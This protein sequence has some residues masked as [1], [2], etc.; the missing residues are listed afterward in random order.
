MTFA[1]IGDVHDRFDVLGQVVD[2]VMTTTPDLA[3][4]L[5]PGDVFDKGSTIA[6]RNTLKE[7]I[8]RMANHAPVYGVYGNHDAPGDLA[9]FEDIGAE[10]P[11]VFADSPGV[12]VVPLPER[13]VRS[14]EPEPKAAILFFPYPT[15]A[16]LLRRGVNLPDIPNAARQALEAM[17]VGYGHRMA[18]YQAK[19][20]STL[21]IGHCDAVG[22]VRAIGQPTVGQDSIA[23]DDGLLNYLPKNCPVLLNHIHRAQDV[24]RA[25]YAG[26]ICRLTWGEVEAKSYTLWHRQENG[27]RWKRHPVNVPP[28]YHVECMLTRSGVVSWEATQGPDGPPEDMPGSW[29]G[30]AVRLRAKYR[31][32]EGVVL[33]EAEKEARALFAEAEDFEFEPVCVPDRAVRAPEVAAARTLAE[34]IQ[35]WATVTGTVLPETALMK[36]ALLETTDPDALVTQVEEALDSAGTVSCPVVSQGR[37]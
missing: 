2:E 36:L 13:L 5:L 4:W 15:Q 30:C 28:M 26:S 9:I 8:R 11:I 6:K 21:M 7:V 16:G 29:A 1:H 24:G 19:G 23:L 37:A 17:F 18:E 27:Y 20:F 22:A 34:K 12:A 33:A 35:A 32:S 14:S 3:A 31:Q 25:S 10:Y